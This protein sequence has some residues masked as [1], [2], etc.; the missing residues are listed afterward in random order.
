MLPR[1]CSERCE[2]NGYE[3]PTKSK[4]IV[5][6]WAMGR[7]PNYWIEAEKFNPERF[8]DSSIDYKGAEFEFIPF[9][10]GRRTFPGINLGIVCKFSFPF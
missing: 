3:I 10:A 4:V 9:G 5:N 8:L 7:D 2:I 6:A 1:E